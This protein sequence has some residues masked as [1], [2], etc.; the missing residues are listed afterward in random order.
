MIMFLYLITDPYYV[1]FPISH[2]LLKCKLSFYSL[3]SDNSVIRLNIPASHCFAA[4][5]LIVTLLLYFFLSRFVIDGILKKRSRFSIA[6]CMFVC[7]SVCLLIYYSFCLSIH[8]S[9]FYPFWLE[10]AGNVQA[11]VSFILWLFRSLAVEIEA[12]RL[13]CMF[14]YVYILQMLNPLKS[15]SQSYY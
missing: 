4:R 8:R 12:S 2:T 1:M 6:C 15:V 13:N 9:I 11:N 14:F 7:L 3:L 5:S 10:H